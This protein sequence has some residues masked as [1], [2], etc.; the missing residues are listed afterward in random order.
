MTTE[1]WIREAAKVGT[2]AAVA[3]LDRQGITADHPQRAEALQMAAEVVKAQVLT[4]LEA[5]LTTK[6]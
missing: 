3:A 4:Q 2:E 1:E 5:N 6:H